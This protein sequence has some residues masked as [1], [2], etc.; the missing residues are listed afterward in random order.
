MST[1]ETKPTILIVDDDAHIRKQMKWALTKDYEV[2]L[3]EDRQT[4]LDIFTQTS[5]GVM[6]LDLGL[7]P[8]TDGATEGI[9]TLE[10]ILRLDPHVKIIVITGNP[11]KQNALAAI[12]LGAYDFQKKP[13]KL[14]ELKVVLQRAY[15]LYSL[16]AEIQALRQQQEQDHAFEGMIG[17]SAQMQKIFSTIERIATTDTSVLITGESGV[18]KELIAKAIHSRS[19]R[20]DKEFI[21]INCAA[22][23]ETLLE[24]ELFGHEPGAFTDAKGQKIGKLERAHLGT[25]FLDEIGDMPFS[26]QPKLLRFLQDQVIERLGGKKAIQLDVRVIAATNKML[27][28]SENGFRE[29]LFFRLNEIHIDVPPLR[30]RGSDTLLLAKSFLHQFTAENNRPTIKGFTAQASKLISDYHWPGNVRE[31]RSRIKRAVVMTDE[32]QITPIDLDLPTGGKLQTLKDAREQA[33]LRVVT[34]ALTRNHG[35]I[36]QAARELEITRPT[37]HDLMK[38]YDLS[39]EDF[40]E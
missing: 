20:A 6:T 5:P 16:E 22:I 4:A 9:R 15:S 25:L 39:R 2:F 14:D 35:N 40:K 33:E 12:D 8:D 27:H 31:L 37:M 11:E 23:P 28:E 7:P 19:L 3:A 21:P 10:E 1:E 30:S 36:S 32:Q 24:D 18:G 38:K 26:L 34:E 13:V 29:D 17:E